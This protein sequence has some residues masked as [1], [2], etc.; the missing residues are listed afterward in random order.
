[1][2]TIANGLRISRATVQRTLRELQQGGW[3]VAEP[4]WRERGNNGS[5]LLFGSFMLK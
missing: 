4:C 5:H 3:I 2:R 1:M